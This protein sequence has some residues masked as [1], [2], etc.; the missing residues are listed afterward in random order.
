MAGL[1]GCSSGKDQPSDSTSETSAT[2]A[3]ANDDGNV[4]G[5]STDN[6]DDPQKNGAAQAGIDLKNPPKPIGEVTVPIGNDGITNTKVEVLKARK[7]DNALLVAFRFTP[8]GTS[9][10]RITIFS[11]MGKHSFNPELIDLE[12]L[13]RYL[14]VRGLTSS[15]IAMKIRMGSSLYGFTAFPLPPDGV[16]TIDIKVSDL[17]PPIENLPLP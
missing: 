4:G 10:E 7:R 15:D 14:Q 9:S 8:E 11:A 12:N 1:V 13:K 16:K 17:A 3:A 6:P 2:T 5:E